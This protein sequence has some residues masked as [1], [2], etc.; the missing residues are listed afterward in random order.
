M[1][2]R[3]A[4]ADLNSTPSQRQRL[5]QSSRRRASQ[6]LENPVVQRPRGETT[7]YANFVVDKMTRVGAPRISTQAFRRG[8]SET[9]DDL[10]LVERLPMVFYDEVEKLYKEK[11]PTFNRNMVKGTLVATNDNKSVAVKI[12]DGKQLQKSETYTDLIAEIAQ[13]NSDI[14]ITDLTFTIYIDPKSL[15]GGASSTI[16]R[17]PA[18]W[19][20]SRNITWKTYVDRQGPISCAA[21]AICDY[22]ASIKGTRG[23]HFGRRLAREGRALQD[24]MGWGEFVTEDQIFNYVGVHPEYRITILRNQTRN[25]LPHTK[26]GI[27]FDSSVVDPFSTV[28]APNTIYIYWSFRHNHYVS[29]KSPT[30]FIAKTFPGRHLCQR[31]CMVVSREDRN[32]EC[33][34]YVKK[35]V[36]CKYGCGL[37]HLTQKDC[38]LVKCRTCPKYYERYQPYGGTTHRCLIYED[39]SER[40]G[41]CEEEDGDGVAPALFVWDIESTQEKVPCQKE[42]VSEFEKDEDGRFIRGGA[43]VYECLEASH[44]PT[45]V[46]FKNVFTK[47]LRKF[48]GPDCLESL[49]SFAAEHNKGNNI[50]IAHN[51]KGYDS[52]LIYDIARVKD[53]KTHII[54]RGTKII[55]LALGKTVFIDSLSF[56]P[57][58]LAA[59][60]KSFA[61]D[62]PMEKGHFPHLFNTPQNQNYVG[63]LPAKEYFDISFAVRTDA[64]LQ[65]FNT[66]YDEEKE[67]GDWNFQERLHAY[68]KNDVEV[69]A[70]I[71]EKVDLITRSFTDMDIWKYST[72]PSFVHKHLLRQ[73]SLS[74]ELPDQKEDPEAYEAKRQEIAETSGWAVLVDAEYWFSRAALRG[75]RTTTNVF[76]HRMTEEELN[77]GLGIRYNDIT[78]EYPYHQIVQEFPVGIPSIHVYNPKFSPCKEHAY[79]IVCDCP[80]DK[81]DRRVKAVK[82]FGTQPTAEEILN[83]PKGGVIC[84]DVTPPKN[85]RH[86]VL[87][88][89]REGKCIAGLE[90]IKA[91]AEGEKVVCFTILEF[92]RALQM[93]YKIDK[94]HRIDWYNMAPSFWTEPLKNFY[95][96][97]MTSSRDLPSPEEQERLIK[98]YEESFGWGDCVRKTFDNNEWKKDAAKKLCFKIMLNC[99]WGK[100]AQNPEQAESMLANADIEDNDVDTLLDNMQE[101]SIK[102]K[103]VQNLSGDT[104][105][106]DFINDMRKTTVTLKDCYL[107]AALHVPA[108]GR[109]Q[110]WEELNKLGDRA[111]YN[112]T[113]SIISIYDPEKYNIPEGDILGEWEREDI[114]SKN[115]G[116]VEFISTG[117]KSYGIRCANGTEMVKCKGLSLTRLHSKAFTFDVF[118]IN[119]T[120]KELLINGLLKHED[121]EGSYGELEISLVQRSFNYSFTQGMR[122]STYVKKFGFNADDQKGFIHGKSLYPFGYDISSE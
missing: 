75:G 98:D 25:F 33:V 45:L 8:D 62:V 115:G 44:K 120:M 35:K 119:Q 39:T 37:Y 79:D 22:L 9:L 114:D 18:G 63:P 27:E 12:T 67:K 55:R 3:R 111:L 85:L 5:A 19:H 117:P 121:P 26:A 101:G 82:K 21:I 56:L 84:A 116:I 36:K 99:A 17:P 76:H 50:F 30:S 53:P 57:G 60:A 1:S 16:S 107:P 11:L 29:V 110:L 86:P 122:T 103:N 31:C 105:K 41:Y 24:E 43:I 83:N 88:S 32:H 81:N 68:C 113:D 13:S 77:Q 58:S 109:L 73:V 2:K 47:E 64:D 92:K 106:I 48:Q 72:A 118:Y 52:R 51:S 59:L 71:V 74:Y 7:E 80:W 14:S 54:T 23:S 91:Y 112:D 87:V 61:G 95:L 89:M 20:D 90:P 49:L 94:V 28:P 70:R 108:Y 4:S 96:K 6:D 93:G 34:P 65:K 100:H 10:Q 102:L 78:S 104:T 38:L 69:L 40:K 42:Y 66:W 15:R 46:Y 97:K